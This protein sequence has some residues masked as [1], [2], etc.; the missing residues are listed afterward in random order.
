MVPSP[1]ERPGCRRALCWKCSLL[2]LIWKTEVWGPEIRTL[3][4]LRLQAGKGGA[5]NEF[6]ATGFLV[7]PERWEKRFLLGEVFRLF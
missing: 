2:W 3:R 4:I 6:H 1:L 7:R 5:Q